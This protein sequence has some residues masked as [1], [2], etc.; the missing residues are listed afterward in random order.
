MQEA[1]AKDFL[2]DAFAH[3]KFI[4]LQPEHDAGVRDISRRTWTKVLW[5]SKKPADAEA[6]IK[7]CGKLRPW[8][9]EAKVHAV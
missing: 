9:R 4:R 5:R 8:A 1:T 7:A 2:N 3:A 6:F